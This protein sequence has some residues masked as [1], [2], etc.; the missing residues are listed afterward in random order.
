MDLITIHLETMKRVFL[1]A[2][3][4]LAITALAADSPSPLTNQTAKVSYSLG[5]NI[6]GSL[7]AQGAE[8]D[9]D[10][11][12]RGLRD[13]LSSNNTL[14]SQQEMMETL[15]AWQTEIRNKRLE[16][17]KAEGEKLRKIGDDW[18]AENAKKPGVITLPSGLQYK[19][20]AAGSG[21]TPTTNDV[22]RA[23]YRGTLIDG[24]EFDSSYTRGQ[25]LI[26]SLDRVVPGWRE[27]LLKMKV[28]D[29]WQ[30][31][32]PSVLGYGERGFPPKI[33]PHAALVFEMELIGIDEGA[34]AAANATKTAPPK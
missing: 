23:H 13:V 5:M 21:K 15:R 6:G 2:G 24:T 17:Q 20:L 10:L 33:P 1:A 29:K 3:L 27:A 32:I 16:Q 25:P 14:L 26:T 18:L 19:V 34:A 30:V 4:T 31:F 8:I 22:V 12:A 11:L 7:K 9:V 28:G